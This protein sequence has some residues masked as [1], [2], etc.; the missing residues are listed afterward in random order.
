MNSFDILVL[1][2]CGVSFFHGVSRGFVMELSGLVGIFLAAWGASQFSY[3]AESWLSEYIDFKYIGILAFI[4]TMIVI[5][6]LVNIVAQM[7][8]RLVGITI[9]SLPNRLLGGAFGVLTMA[10]F[11]SCVL[12]VMGCFN[13]GDIEFLLNARTDS[14]SYPLIEKIAPKLI[15]YFDVN[16][17]TFFN[18]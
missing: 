16:I 5:V 7:L 8:H 9:L 2:L 17:G 14:F 10:F 4:L 6:I 3:I 15:P 18:A 13:M 12:V 1:I 11:L